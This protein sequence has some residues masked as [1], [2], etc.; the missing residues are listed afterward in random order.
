MLTGC[1]LRGWGPGA[2]SPAAALP[3]AAQTGAHR[4]AVQRLQRVGVEERAGVRWPPRRVRA[5]RCVP[6]A[7]PPRCRPPSRRGRRAAPA[8]PSPRRSGAVAPGPPAPRPSPATRPRPRSARPASRFA[9]PT[10]HARAGTAV[11]SRR[12]PPGV[13]PGGVRRWTDAATLGVPQAVPRQRGTPMIDTSSR[14]RVRSVATTLA[15]ALTLTLAAAAGC[16][17]RREPPAA[18]GARQAA[19]VAHQRPSEDQDRGRHHRAADGRAAQRRA[20]RLRRRDR[21]LRRLL[22]RL[23]GRPADRVGHA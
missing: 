20:H 13:R 12:S 17:N 11:N 23:R 16:D 3:V 5:G 15:V 19:R 2:R 1:R 10:Q 4:L 14:H 21:P 8:P 9:S 6:G 22:P 18:L 7:R